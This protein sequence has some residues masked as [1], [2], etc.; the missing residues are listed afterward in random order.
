MVLVNVSDQASEQLERII[1]Y[2]QITLH[3]P[4]AAGSLR[5]DFY[6]TANSLVRLPNA[7][8]LCRHPVLNHLEHRIISLRRHQYN[9]IYHTEDTT[10]FIDAVYHQ[11]QDYENI[12][13]ADLK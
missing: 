6:L 8:R 2:I 1:D 9:L 11:L 12:F 7:G 13:A 5:Y 10:V 4:Q 3:N